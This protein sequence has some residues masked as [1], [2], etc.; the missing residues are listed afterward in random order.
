MVK[1]KKDILRFCLEKS[2]LT[3]SS[4]PQRVKQGR[5]E[6]KNMNG[7]KASSLYCFFR[8]VWRSSI[9]KRPF[10]IFMCFLFLSFVVLLPFCS[11]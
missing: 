10:L 7:L 2:E 1:C 5:E 3:C 11:T 8:T 4:Y 6:Q 9:M